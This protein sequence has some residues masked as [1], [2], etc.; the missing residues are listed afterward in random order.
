MRLRCVILVVESL[1]PKTTLLSLGYDVCCFDIVLIRIFSLRFMRPRHHG[2]WVEQIGVGKRK[3][4]GDC[5]LGER[6]NTLSW[7]QLFHPC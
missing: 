5:D 6:L 3:V 1:Y 4:L 7:H 2:F